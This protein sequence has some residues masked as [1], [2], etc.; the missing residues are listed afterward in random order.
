MDLK[1][2][3]K[4]KPADRQVDVNRRALAGESKRMIDLEDD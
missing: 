4:T 2:I 1:N 3:S